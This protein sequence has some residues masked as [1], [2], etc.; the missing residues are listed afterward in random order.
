MTS[1][2]QW[3]SATSATR[4]LSCPASAAFVAAPQSIPPS[5]PD[6][7]G[8]LAHLAMGAWLESGAW[9]DEDAG[10]ALQ[11]AWDREAARWNVDAKRLRDS[12]MTR[13]R[14]RARGAELAGLLKA[15]GTRARSEAFLQDD[16]HGL[17]GQL[18]IV[19]DD[20]IGGAVVDLK[21][22][23][24]GFSDGVRTQLLI[25]AHLFGKEC[26]HL[27][28]V[29][30]AFSLRHGAVHV[31]FSQAEIDALL[32][33]IEEARAQP[34]MEVPDERGCKYCRRRLRC[35]PHWAAAMTW[36]D[37]DCV[38]G[39]ISKVEAS[40]AGMTAVRISTAVGEQW[41]TG[42]TSLPVRALGSGSTIRVTEV[43][44]R[45]EGTERE[46]LATRSTRIAISD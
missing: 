46:W 17:Y 31:E 13:S 12:I 30:V 24:H 6:N 9:L 36:T 37:P 41:V 7:A 11:V 44:G 4:L 28:D 18:D 20:P 34:A 15:S 39:Q 1:A 45:G 2:T 5:A 33:R 43:A 10:S 38:E 32:A 40:V 29:L 16:V 8:T 14:L 35:E 25:Y 3:L 21:T 23:A 42:I 27:P 19:V 22:G 26:G